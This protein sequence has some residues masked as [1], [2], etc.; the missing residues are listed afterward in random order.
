MEDPT[1]NWRDDV[2]GG[3][4]ND[5]ADVY[6]NDKFPTLQGEAEAGSVVKV[7]I[8]N[9]YVGEVTT[10]ENGQWS[11]QISA[12]LAEGQHSYHAE[13]IRTGTD[14]SA[15]SGVRTITI[16]TISPE[17]PTIT[18]VTDNVDNAGNTVATTTTVANGGFTNDTTPLIKGTAEANSSVLLQ[19]KKE[20]GD[21]TT[22]PVTVGIDGNWECELPELDE[23]RYE[24]RAYVLD[25]AGN[26]SATLDSSSF[27]V[28]STPP[29]APEITSVTDNVDSAGNT[30]ATTT[31]VANGG[32]TNDTMPQIKGTAEANSKVYVQYAKDGGN[33]TTVTVTA[34]A[35][36]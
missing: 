17:E 26:R 5:Y 29:V 11:F 2:I 18:S 31:I 12:P 10:P 24:Y 35:N 36:G 19:Y 14:V 3:A 25:D 32:L 7:Y 13:S 28:D 4:Y 9:E 8:D 21:W 20:E 1:I 34:D 23:G 33:W 6:T 15:T 16:D 22:V 27:T 30:V